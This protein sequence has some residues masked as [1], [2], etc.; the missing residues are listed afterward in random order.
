MLCTVPGTGGFNCASPEGTRLGGL[1]LGIRGGGL[2]RGGV[3]RGGVS[4][5]RP[6]PKIVAF[7]FIGAG[8][9]AGVCLRCATVGTSR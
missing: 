9:G 2:P 7:G 6:T 8:A 5:T 4:P 3:V 1:G